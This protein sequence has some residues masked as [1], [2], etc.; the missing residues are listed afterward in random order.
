MLCLKAGGRLDGVDLCMLS[1]EYMH[2][3]LF[4]YITIIDTVLRNICH[5]MQVEITRFGS[6]AGYRVP[7]LLSV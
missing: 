2:Y 3:I 6:V 1:V 5:N 7:G 4:S